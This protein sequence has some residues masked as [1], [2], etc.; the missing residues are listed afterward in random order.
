MTHARVSAAAGVSPI[1]ALRSEADDGW[2][3][4]DQRRQRTG[5][6]NLTNAC[7]RE[8]CGWGFA[9]SR[10]PFST[11]ALRVVLRTHPRSVRP[12]AP[13]G[14]VQNRSAASAGP[15]AARPKRSNQPTARERLRLGFRP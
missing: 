8:C 12:F 3:T 9:H 2:C 6:F 11:G 10:A 14:T 4:K 7:A 5:L 13:F 15:A 1:A